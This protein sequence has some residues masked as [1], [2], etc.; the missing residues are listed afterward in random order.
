MG[1]LAYAQLALQLIPQLIAVGQDAAAF[2]K[3]AYDVIEG[4]KHPTDAD[5]TALKAKEAALDAQ[6]NRPVDEG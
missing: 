5:W 2:A 4:G 6:I 3:E 1:A